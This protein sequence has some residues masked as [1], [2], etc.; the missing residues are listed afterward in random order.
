M[1]IAYFDAFAGIAADMVLGAFISAGINVNQVQEEL[2]KIGIGKVDIQ[3]STVV[4]SNI[5]ATK[6]NVAKGRDGNDLVHLGESHELIQASNKH[7]GF[8]ESQDS[9][10]SKGRSYLEIRNLIEC[11]GLSHNVKQRSLSV[12]EHL[13]R[14]EMVI[15]NSKEEEIHFHEVGS[16]ESILEIVGVSTCLELSRVEAVYTCPIRVGSGGFIKAQHGILPIPTP[17][18]L[19]ILKGY[20]IILDDTPYEMTTPTGAAIVKAFSRGVIEPMH[21]EVEKIGYG[22]G[23]REF[24]KMPGLLRIMIGNA[25]FNDNKVKSMSKMDLEPKSH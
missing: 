6:V 4:R 18:T 25:C 23:T 12:L 11:S 8:G 2:R 19:E 14:A 13:A 20:P 10:R 1:R 3:L 16:I 21:L 7:A 5:A 15:H 22:A 24:E 9:A 17:A